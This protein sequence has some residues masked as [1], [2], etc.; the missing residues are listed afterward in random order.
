MPHLRNGIRQEGPP[1]AHRSW[2]VNDRISRP[3][4]KNLLQ[5]S[6]APTRDIVGNS[7]RKCVPDVVIGGAA[8][9]NAEACARL[10]DRDQPD[11]L[12]AR[13]AALEMVRDARRAA[14]VIDHVRSLYRKGSSQLD[15]VDVN[16]VIGEMV[17]M[18]RN[19]A[20]R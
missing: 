3:V 7:T 9:T 12:E 19:E 4:S 1:R 20:N 10:L 14:E 13:A 2:L 17:I 15:V 11:V 8:V 16:E 5:H 18:L 6:A